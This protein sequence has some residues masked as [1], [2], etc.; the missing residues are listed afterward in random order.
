MYNNA[1]GEYWVLIMPN[2]LCYSKKYS[3]WKSIFIYNNSIKYFQLQNHGNFISGVT[4]VL[5]L[6]AP[7]LNLYV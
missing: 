7:N 4:I 3:Q 5:E 6:Q 1:M 2:V